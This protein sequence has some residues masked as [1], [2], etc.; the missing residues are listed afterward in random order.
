VANAASFCVNVWAVSSGGRIDSRYADSKDGVP[1]TDEYR[2]LVT[3]SGWAFAI[4]GVIYLAESVFMV[5]RGG[6][7]L[8]RERLHGA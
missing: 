8:G 7:L 5:R 6:H 3:P 4:W 2:S 1:P